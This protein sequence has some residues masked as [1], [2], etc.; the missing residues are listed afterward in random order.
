M[1]RRVQLPVLP[2]SS[3]INKMV[4]PLVPEGR[5]GEFDQTGSL[6]FSTQ[7]DTGD[8][9]RINIF[10]AGGDTHVAMRRVQAEISDFDALHLPDIYRQQISEV[11]D[12]LVLVCGVTGSGKSSTLAAML[13]YINHTRSLHIITIEDPVEFHFVGAKS[14]ISQRE[15]GI[16][17]RNFPEALRVVVRQDP[18]VILIGEMRDRETVLAAIQAAETG[19]LVMG[20]LHCAD[21]PLSFSRILEFFDRSE[22][23]FIRSSL[24]N[25]LRAIMVQRLIPGIKEGSRYPATEVLLGNSVVKRKILEAQDDELHGVLHAYRADG[26]RDF[27]HSLCELVE[28][29]KVLRDVAM[30]YAPNREALKSM[31]KGIDAASSGVLT[32]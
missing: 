20:S 15:I 32:R 27:T 11:G 1:L 2:D 19:H 8:R 4:L 17:A 29:Q 21:V 14:I 9:F 23:T 5:L 30:E 12:G 3:Y 24:A 16:D 28:N 31:L 10:K 7:I 26:M 18:D 6:D 25:S 13:D 22:H